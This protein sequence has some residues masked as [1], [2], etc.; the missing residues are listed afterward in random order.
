[1]LKFGSLKFCLCVSLV[2]HAVVFGVVKWTG[3][4]RQAPALR[5]EG[6]LLTLHLVAAP[7]EPAAAAAPR[8]SESPAPVP[9]PVVPPAPVLPPP[10]PVEK[11]AEIPVTPEPVT[12]PD[13]PKPEFTPESAFVEP[14]P[15]AETQTATIAPSTTQ[16]RGDGSSVQPGGDATT[17]HVQ[18]GIRA[19]PNYLK[20]PEPAYPLVARRRQQEGLVLLEVKVSAHGRAAELTVKKS[21]GH[22][23]LDEAALN[24]VRD[25]EFAPAR[26]GAT[27]VESRIEVPVQFKLFR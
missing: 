27:P 7:A 8:V 18:P 15:N 14:K 19:H 23:V 25:W 4:D 13:P 21:S 10:P 3:I 5:Q 24:A 22:P 20:N 16:A 26:V 17:T 2:F 11:I 9:A 12:I 6:E 1:M